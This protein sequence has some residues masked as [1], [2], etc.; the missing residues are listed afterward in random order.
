[1]ADDDKK[2]SINTGLIEYKLEMAER[3]HTEIKGILEQIRADNTEIKVSIGQLKV[4]S[5]VWG[6][7]GGAMSVIIAIGLWFIKR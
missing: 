1:M 3:Q 6:M 2:P 7:M 5:G 4:K